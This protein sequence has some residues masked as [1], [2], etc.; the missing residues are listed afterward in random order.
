MLLH[1]LNLHH[2]IYVRKHWLLWKPG[3]WFIGFLQ[4]SAHGTAPVV[5][6]TN[7]SYLGK[8]MNLFCL[9]FGNGRMGGKNWCLKCRVESCSVIIEN[10]LRCRTHWLF[11]MTLECCEQCVEGSGRSGLLIC[12][13]DGLRC[14]GLTTSPGWSWALS[15][16]RIRLIEINTGCLRVS[17]LKFQAQSSFKNKF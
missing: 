4:S 11:T 14:F 16:P 3:L 17:I 5:I 1:Y 2:H 7:I 13:V 9:F 6:G 12:G 8:K 15:A 10:C